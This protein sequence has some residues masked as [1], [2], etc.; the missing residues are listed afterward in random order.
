MYVSTENFLHT[1]PTSKTTTSV[2][3]WF[4][5][6]VF[7]EKYP[8]HLQPEVCILKRVFFRGAWMAQWVQRLSLAQVMIL[9]SW[10]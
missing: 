2:L 8:V 7:I 5:G 10:D 3:Q 6:V 9:E 1:K 4:Q